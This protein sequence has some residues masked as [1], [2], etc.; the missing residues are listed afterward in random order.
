MNI[1]NVGNNHVN[2]YLLDSGTNRLL[3]DCGY[4]GEIYALGRTMRQTGYTL[5]QIDY[6]CVTHFHVDHAGAVQELKDE[7]AKFILFGCQ[8]D[9]YTTDGKN[10][11][12]KMEIHGPKYG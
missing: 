5:K 2:I 10:D 7:G 4:P 9:I 6:I 1:Y 3:I 12:A 11:W 8:I